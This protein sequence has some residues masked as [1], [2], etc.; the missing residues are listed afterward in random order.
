MIGT[1]QTGITKNSIGNGE[2]KELISST[3]GHE[4]RQGMRAGGGCR[5][6]GNQ[7]GKNR[8]TVIV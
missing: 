6:K 8:T 4:L 7:G 5:V 1:K 2:A 3:H